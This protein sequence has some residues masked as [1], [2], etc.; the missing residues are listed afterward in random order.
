MRRD[1]RWGMRPRDKDNMVCYVDWWDSEDEKEV[2]ADRRMIQDSNHPMAH[3]EATA[4]KDMEV[5]MHQDMVLKD[6]I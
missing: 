3:K 6:S 5:G 4:L 1:H 2:G